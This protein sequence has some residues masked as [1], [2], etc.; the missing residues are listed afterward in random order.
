VED[1]DPV[2]IARISGSSLEIRM[3]QADAASPT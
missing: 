2:L 1:E 3:M